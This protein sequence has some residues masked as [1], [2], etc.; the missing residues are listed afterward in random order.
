MMMMMMMMMMMILITIINR[1]RNPQFS[2]DLVTFPKEI[3]KWKTF[4]IFCAVSEIQSTKSF[5]KY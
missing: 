2:V 5:S 4:F 3:L 1:L